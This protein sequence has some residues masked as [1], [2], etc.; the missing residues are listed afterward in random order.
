MSFQS[1]FFAFFKG[2]KSQAELETY[3][4]ATGQI[5]DL[6]A[7][8]QTQVL[9]SPA[10]AGTAPWER[11]VHHQQAMAFAWIARALS[12]ISATLMEIDAQE[13]PATAGYLPVVTFG[14][15]K[16]FYVQVPDFI[17]ATWEAL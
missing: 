7:A 8:I 10:R 2:E 13:D 9:A 4:R 6:E 15:I 3:R 17:H 16:A 14:Q 12:T 1:A 5:D 11:P